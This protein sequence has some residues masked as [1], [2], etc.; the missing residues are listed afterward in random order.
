MTINS[1]KLNQELKD[2]GI[3]FVSCNSNGVVIDIDGTTEIQDQP[4]V[5]AVITDHDPTDYVQQRRDS[6]RID[7]ENLPDWASWTADEVETHITDNV[8][9]LA[10]AK[11]VLIK[12]GRAIIYFRNHVYPDMPGL[13]PDP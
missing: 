2:A 6:A 9:S 13:N 1:T 4:A 5:A 7:F 3:I 11:V 10:E 12:M 8:N